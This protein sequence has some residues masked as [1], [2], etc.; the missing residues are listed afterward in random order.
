VYDIRCSLIVKLAIGIHFLW[1]GLLLINPDVR[2]VPAI[3]IVYNL[4]WRS[5]LLTVLA[6]SIASL[7]AVL[8][9]H[10]FNRP[11]RRGLVLFVP[12][13]L[14]L[15]I[16]IG[17]PFVAFDRSITYSLAFGVVAFVLAFLHTIALLE[18]FT[19]GLDLWPRAQSWYQ[20]WRCWFLSLPDSWQIEPSDEKPETE[21]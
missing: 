17:G 14:S 2:E 20:S 10:F 4:L 1:A 9:M 8:S 13:Q 3:L 12:Q 16:G 7:C 15:L 6:F 5:T 18:Y 19:Y 11:T 21:K